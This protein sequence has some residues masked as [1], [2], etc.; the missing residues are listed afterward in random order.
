VKKDLFWGTPESRRI[1]SDYFG[2]VR[3]LADDIGL[4]NPASRAIWR[5]L[6]IDGKSSRYRS[7]PSR[8]PHAAAAAPAARS[9]A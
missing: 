3:M 7:E 6:G 5:L 9:A 1:L 8:A 2:D 4:M